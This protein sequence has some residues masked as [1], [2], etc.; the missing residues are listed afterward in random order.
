[1]RK[2]VYSLAFHRHSAI[3]TKTVS[4]GLLRVSNKQTKN[5][6]SVLDTVIVMML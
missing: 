6:K 5:S 3:N 1:M 2:H 4:N